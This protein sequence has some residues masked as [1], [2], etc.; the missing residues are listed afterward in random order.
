MSVL[1]VLLERNRFLLSW[2]ARHSLIAILSPVGEVTTYKYISPMHVQCFLGRWVLRKFYYCLHCSQTCIFFSNYVLESPLGKAG[3]LKIL[4]PVQVTFQVSTLQ[5]FSWPWWEGSGQVHWFC[6][7]YRG[8]F[9]YYWMHR[10][11]WFLQGPLAYGTRYHN[12]HK[13]AFVCGWMSILLFKKGDKKRNI[14]CHHDVDITSIY[15]LI[16]MFVNIS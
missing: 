8:L 1:W 14:L 11:A 15:F 10:W 5:I 9:D 16:W 6:R 13:G 2:P 12:T 4:S 7:L 3:L